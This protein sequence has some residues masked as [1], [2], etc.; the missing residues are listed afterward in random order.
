M[1]SFS[2]KWTPAWQPLTA[3]R[4]AEER[5]GRGLNAV[6]SRA[7]PL[8]NKTL[9]HT[10][11][12]A[13]LNNIPERSPGNEWMAGA[14]KMNNADTEQH[15]TLW[16]CSFMRKKYDSCS[17]GC[18]HPSHYLIYACHLLR[19]QLEASF[20]T[21]VWL[22]CNTSKCCLQPSINMFSICLSASLHFP[23]GYKSIKLSANH[24]AK[25][26]KCSFEQLMPPVSEM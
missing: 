22:R 12:F 4:Q 6:L 7:S 3:C 8:G 10:Q 21:F 18:L 17:G 11:H 13:T 14:G 26:I 19:S 5:R 1:K 20:K 16:K 9:A 24:V 25:F 2:G 15:C 23:V